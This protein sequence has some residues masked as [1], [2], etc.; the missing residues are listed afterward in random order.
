MSAPSYPNPKTVAQMAAKLQPMVANKHHHFWADDLSI[1]DAA[2]FRHDRL[3]GH[4]QITDTYLLALAVKHGG[5]FL[6]IDG[7]IALNT[8]VGARDHHLAALLLNR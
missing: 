4:R 2:T 8:V 3:I 1:M 6:T 7:G 5:R